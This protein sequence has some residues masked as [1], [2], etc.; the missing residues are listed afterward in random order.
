MERVPVKRK[1]FELNDGKKV[2]ITQAS[3]M[4]KLPLETAHAK[5][6]RK[7][8]HYG[9]DPTEWTE[10]QQE[11][12]FEMVEG[13]GGGLDAQIA[14]LLPLCVGEYEDGGQCDVNTLMSDEIVPLIAF[15]RGEGDE[16]GAVPLDR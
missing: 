4:Q 10:E 3:G 1:L 14:L 15:I 12:F 5:A 16:E 7:C 6:L 8:R 13:Y 11:E 2:W 9:M